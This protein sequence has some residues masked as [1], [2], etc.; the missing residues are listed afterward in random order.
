MQC[1][2][3][4][5]DEDRVIDSRAI[6]EGNAI[7]RRRKCLACG[8]RFTTYERTEVQP[9]VV[10][11]KDSS[12]ESFSREKVLAGMMKA[13]EKRNISLHDLENLAA[14]IEASIFEEFDSEVSTQVIGE[15]VSEALKQIDHVAYVRFASVYR[16]FKD[17]EEFLRELIPLARPGLAQREAKA[18]E[19]AREL[20]A[21]ARPQTVARTDEPTAGDGSRVDSILAV[22][23]SLGVHGS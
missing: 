6:G 9:R 11:K 15:K 22:A 12:R 8:K 3:C 16:D 20:E 21:A 23:R 7:R 10:I 5:T 17:V 13:C 18:S 1:P 19:S 4:R 2:F 14:S